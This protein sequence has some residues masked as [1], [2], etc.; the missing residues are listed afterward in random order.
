M[1]VIPTSALF[2]LGSYT[3]FSVPRNLILSGGEGM[4]YLKLRITLN[5]GKRGI[6]LDKLE[7]IVEEMRRFLSSLGDDIELTEPT[8]WVGMEFVNSSLGFTSEYEYQVDTPKLARFNG[9]I[10]ALAKSEFPSSLRPA[11]SESFFNMAAMLDVDEIADVGVFNEDGTVMPFEISQRTATLARFI[12]V[13]PFRQTEGAVQG[14]IHSLYKESKPPHFVLRELST[15]DLIKCLY[16]ID[17]Y[18]AIVK[19]L[20]N[21]DQV[22]HVR[23]TVV[24]DTRERNIDHVSVK[25]IL[26]A[27]QY[28]FA[29]VEKFLRTGK[30]Q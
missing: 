23:G 20:E 1:F 10:I 22:L 9:A 29:D 30:A 7:H 28:G 15:G 16:E 12:D 25:R 2:V 6:K 8:S 14:K 21:K 3:E 5:K 4:S 24:T 19:A 27:E 26:L 17:D 18:P 11:T 13:L